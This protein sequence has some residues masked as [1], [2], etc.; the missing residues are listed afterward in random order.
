MVIWSVHAW[1]STY[2]TMDW[3]ELDCVEPLRDN[4]VEY[5]TLS[6]ICDDIEKEK[7]TVQKLEDFS[8]S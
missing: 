2:N 8:L 6:Q 5:V 7:N 4:T 3:M 1:H